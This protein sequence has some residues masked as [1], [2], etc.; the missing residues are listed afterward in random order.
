MGKEGGHGWVRVDKGWYP[1]W[2]TAKA[3]SSHNTHPSPRKGPPESLTTNHTHPTVS[4]Q[5]RPPT[6]HTD[7]PPPPPIDQTNLFFF[8]FFFFFFISPL[9]RSHKNNTF[10]FHISP[11]NPN[12]LHHFL[13]EL[14]L[15]SKYPSNGTIFEALVPLHPPNPHI[16]LKL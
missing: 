1:C 5:P 7:I 14:F 10:L 11:P 8:F 3:S 6:H 12:F 2:I 15:S 4:H 16:V 9:S 13:Q